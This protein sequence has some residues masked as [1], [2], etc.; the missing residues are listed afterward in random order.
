MAPLTKASKSK[1]V[2]NDDRQLRAIFDN[3]NEHAIC[4]LDALGRIRSWNMSAQRLTGYAAGELLGKNYSVFFS[5]EEARRH[6]HKAALAIAVKK[7]RFVSEGTRYKKDGS[8]FWARSFITLVEDGDASAVSFTLIMQDITRERAREMKREEYIGIASHELKNPITTL[9]LYAELLAKRLQSD[10]D[11]KNLHMLRDIQG[12]T[13]RLVTL[14]DDLLIVSKIQ[15]S[16]LELHKSLFD[17]KSLIRKII[18]DF[19]NNSPSHKIIFT[20]SFKRQV[21]ADKDRIAQVLINL[22]TNAIKY[23]PRAN[24]VLVHIGRA[25]K[26][27]TISIQDF[28]PGIEKSDQREIFTRFFRTDDA[29]SGNVAGSGLGLYISKEIMQKHREQLSLKSVEGKGTVFSFTLSTA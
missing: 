4:M 25:G 11:K 28:G 8:H 20:G 2:T 10:S 17:P 27:C 19:R 13:A 12:Q 18:Q 1:I 5:K 14:V 22:L 23:S 29:E 6:I 3:T 9:S 21:R 7:G 24:K 15:G 16:T 26:K